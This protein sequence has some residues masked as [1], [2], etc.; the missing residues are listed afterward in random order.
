MVFYPQPRYDMGP[1]LDQLP[2][3]ATISAMARKTGIAARQIHRWMREGVPFWSADRLATRFYRM[4]GELWPEWDRG[5]SSPVIIDW[6]ERRQR[7]AAERLAAERA[8]RAAVAATLPPADLS[9]IRSPG[10]FRL[11]PK[12]PPPRPSGPPPPRAGVSGDLVHI[13][14]EWLADSPNP[15]G[16]PPRKEE[17][18]CLCS[19]LD[20]LGRPVLIGRCGDG[21]DRRPA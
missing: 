16:L 21:C 3:G 18:S 12:M 2:P 8:Q 10:D 5:E 17:A 14:P 6:T 19:T 7:E 13:F 1:V 9:D 20:H 4:P 11:V 15:P